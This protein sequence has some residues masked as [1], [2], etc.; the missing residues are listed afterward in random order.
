MRTY[1]NSRLPS[2]GVRLLG[3]AC[4]V[5]AYTSAAQGQDPPTAPAR[6]PAPAQ[7][8]MPMTI[9]VAVFPGLETAEQAMAQMQ[10]T[11]KAQVESYAVVSK[12]Q[13]GQIKVRER[14][15]KWE[16]RGDQAGKAVD[17]AVALLG[18]RPAEGASDTA[19][20]RRASVSQADAGTIQQ[21]L[22]PDHSAIVLVVP[23]GDATT[24][25][26]GLEDAR[27]DRVVVAELIPVP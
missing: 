2:A 20:A 21:V 6:S 25:K 1:P 27:A 8:T 12:D 22:M 23:A 9:I 11:Q 17:G 26:S 24:M 13:Q 4:V 14:H 18:Q 10:T 5:A 7:D 16:T 3:F 19:A 15:T